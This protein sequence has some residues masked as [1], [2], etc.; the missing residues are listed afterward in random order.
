MVGDMD[1]VR[2]LG[3]AGVRTA[4]VAEPGAPPRYSRFVCARLAWFDPWTEPEALV[5]E[6]L[7]FAAKQPTPP[8]LFYEGDGDLLLVSRHREL[9]RQGFRFVVPDPQLVEDLIDKRRFAVLAERLGLPVPRTYRLD[10]ADD[11][12]D[13]L[14]SALPLI[15]KPLTRRSDR[16]GSAVPW[17]KAMRVESP[18]ALRDIVSDVREAGGEALVQ[19]LVPG[20]ETHIVSYHAYVDESGETAAEFTGRKLRTYPHEYG[21]SSALLVTDLPEVAELGREVVRRLGLRGV[22]KIDCKR[23]VDGNLRVLEVNPRFSLWHHPAA[24]AGTNVPVTVYADL[25]GLRRP[26]RARPLADADWVWLTKDV[27]AARSASE[28][29]SRWLRFVLTCQTRSDFSL[30]DPLPFVR[31]TLIPALRRRLPRRSA[32]SPATAAP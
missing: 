2:P 21:H 20:P 7:S 12:I 4:V 6:L 10:R 13:E 1:L 25:V 23:G 15:V 30:D 11:R 29:M 24:A 19:E 18:A 27:R 3:L 22:C 16:W 26:T 8:V 32:H 14:E 17:A 5:K 28:S 31:G 9:L